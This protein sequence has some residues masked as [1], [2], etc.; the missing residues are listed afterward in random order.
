MTGCGHLLAS[1]PSPTSTCGGVRKC[2]TTG[3]RHLLASL[4]SPNTSWQIVCEY[5]TM[6]C[7]H[8]PASLPSP[9]STCV[10]VSEF[11]TMG[12]RHWP[13]SLPS[14]CVILCDLAGVCDSA[15]CPRRLPSYVV[16][17][18][19]SSIVCLVYCLSLLVCDVYFYCGNK[20]F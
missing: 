4:P 7:G 10:D 18:G 17:D 14:P 6:G 3:C 9:N 8:L 13:A 2:Q 20:D 1:L 19:A 16:V 11:Q 15:S 5:R 12:C